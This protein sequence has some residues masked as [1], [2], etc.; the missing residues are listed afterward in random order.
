M[1]YQHSITHTVATPAG[2]KVKQ[3]DYSAGQHTGVA[4]TI[5]A[6]TPVTIPNVAIDV[7]AMVSLFMY[8]ERDITVTVNDDGT[9][10]ATVDLIGGVP[11]VWTNDGYYSNPL[12]AVDATSIKADLAAGADAEL[13]LDVIYD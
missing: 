1:S 3:N 8:C 9:P 2:S 7:S 10:D 4:Q 12:G 13:I 6:G 11:L 5:T